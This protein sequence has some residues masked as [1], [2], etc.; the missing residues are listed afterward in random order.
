MSDSLPR[1]LLA[2]DDGT[3]LLIV[4][5]A[6][7]HAGVT[8]TAVEDGAAA[9]E[10]FGR[11]QPRLVILDVNMPRMNG[12]EACRAIRAH[13]LG[14]HV[15][16]LILT[17]RD[18]V[19]SVTQAYA[20]GATDFATKGM[21]PRLITERARFLLR[22]GALREDLAANRRRLHHA[23][24]LAR[25]GHWE[26]DSSGRTIDVSDMVAELIGR[27]AADL[28][29]LDALLA[30]LSPDDAQAL[31]GTLAS[32]QATGGRFRVEVCTAAGMHLSV[33]GASA[34]LGKGPAARA[35]TLAIQDITPLRNAERHAR[36]LA[37]TDP[38]TGLA[39]RG[40]F[41]AFIGSETGGREPNRVVSVI[42]IR[43]AGHERVLHSAGAGAA[44]A[45][46][47]G[48][49]ERL[50][51]VIADLSS[52]VSL[53][54]DAARRVLLAHA[55]GGEFLVGIS[56]RHATADAPK[57][58]ARLLESLR[59]PVKGPDWEV[60]LTAHGGLVNWPDDVADPDVLVGAALASAARHASH[61]TQSGCE[62]FSANAQAAARR[63]LSLESGLRR[64]LEQSQLRLVYQPRLLLDN[65]HV[66]GAEALLRWTHPELGEIS[67]ADVIPLAEETG[68][69]VNIGAWVL[70]EACSYTVGLRRALNRHICVSVNVAAQQLATGQRF[71]GLVAESLAA[72]GLPASAL[73]LELTESTVIHADADALE[74]LATLRRMGV[75]IALDD[76]G[77][78]YSSLGYLQRLPVDCL[79]IDRSFVRDLGHSRPAQ[80]VVQALLTMAESL[81][82]R[83]VA[84]G[85]ETVEQQAYLQRHG[86]REG[87]GFL[88]AR[89]LPPAEF[90]KFVRR[91]AGLADVERC[92]AG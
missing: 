61:S 58:A 50:A 39:N 25:V 48:A 32:W 12:F 4:E 33:Q 54:E 36:R 43:V 21:S 34:L 7:E 28:T 79:K 74:T 26:V 70:R 66:E 10:A 20:A 85:V 18:D 30:V 87:Q 19:E 29:D 47:V 1:V 62:F 86:C 65:G 64:A 71:A 46:L 82:M 24:Q 63:R 9:V 59:T 76:F 49:A 8:V 56:S 6:L 23:Q 37:E 17:G 52:H 81:Q 40:Q 38:L 15:P 60:I 72:T 53:A 11:E 77:T 45:V 84:E 78:G 80:G 16:I 83:T 75:S 14:R 89:P 67:P 88:Y 73:E 22:T 3:Q 5:A 91:P 92:A 51:A 69:I 2:D 68:L 44:D 13:P 57:V 31:R 27:N 42:A 41:D 55:G 90:E 35:L